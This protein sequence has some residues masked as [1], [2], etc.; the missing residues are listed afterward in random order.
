MGLLSPLAPDYEGSFSHTDAGRPG[1]TW[2]ITGLVHV[3]AGP[4]AEDMGPIPPDYS[5][6]HA[7]NKS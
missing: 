2:K 3:K 7:I 1:P 4:S 5:S 6:G